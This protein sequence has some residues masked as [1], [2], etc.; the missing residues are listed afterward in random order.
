MQL[1]III[2]AS[3]LVGLAIVWVLLRLFVRRALKD[4]ARRL[5]RLVLILLVVQFILGMTANL[6]VTIPD[7]QPWIVFHQVGPILLHTIN[8]LLLLDF[9]IMSLA[10]AVKDGRRVGVAVWGLASVILAFASGLLFVNAGQNDLFS[11]TMALG[12]LG[13]FLSFGYRAFNIES[14]RVEA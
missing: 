6:W 14:Q 9:S 5:N 10:L 3:I 2:T 12:F 1:G 7:S 4:D 11:F 13:A 8:A